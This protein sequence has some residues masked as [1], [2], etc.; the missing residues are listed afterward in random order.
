MEPGLPSWCS[1]ERPYPARLF[2]YLVIASDFLGGAP[3]IFDRREKVGFGVW[4]SILLSCS[5]SH[6]SAEGRLIPPSSPF[7]SGCPSARRRYHSHPSITLQ[8]EVQGTGLPLLGNLTGEGSRSLQRSVSPVWE[9]LYMRAQK[10]HFVVPTPFFAPLS[11][12]LKPVDL[13]WHTA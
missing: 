7:D 9:K 8:R 12:A 3:P 11:V 13:A 1:C 5:Y 2:R 4:C 6:Q 10:A